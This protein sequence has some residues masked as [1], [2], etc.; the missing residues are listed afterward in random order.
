MGRAMV[1]AVNQNDYP[2]AMGAFFIMG[3]ITIVANFVADILYVYLDP[4][5]EYDSEG[6]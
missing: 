6:S 5:I 2:L 1:D 3:S 4:R